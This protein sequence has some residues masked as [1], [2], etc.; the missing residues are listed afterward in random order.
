MG[1]LLKK[2][3]NKLS[4]VHRILIAALAVCYENML[5]IYFLLRPINHRLKSYSCSP[6]VFDIILKI[7][8]ILHWAFLFPFICYLITSSYLKCRNQ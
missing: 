1:E 7:F 3:W 5:L 6:E 8:I 2:K 4:L